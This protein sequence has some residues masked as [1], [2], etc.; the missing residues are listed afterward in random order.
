MKW[1]V[2]PKYKE[3][4]VEWLGEVPEGWDVKKGRYI[5]TLLGSITPSEDELIE[6]G[7]GLPY[8]KVDDLNQIDGS[9]KLAFT[10][11]RVHGYRAPHGNFLLFPKR[12]AAIFTNKVAIV[13]QPLLFD[14]N[15]MG[16]RIY[17]SFDAKFITYCLIARRSVM[18]GQRLFFARWILLKSL[19]ELLFV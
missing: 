10:K 14:P 6:N 2:Y 17:S 5:G 7:N 1:Q 8:A 16:W 18:A 12:G 19:P 9:L 11:V 3:S 15:L 4:G 13:E